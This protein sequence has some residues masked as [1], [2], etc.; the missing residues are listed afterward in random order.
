MSPCGDI[1][2]TKG[3]DYMRKSILNELWFGNLTPSEKP[4]EASP[5]CKALTDKRFKI[6]DKLCQM[7]TEQQLTLLSEYDDAVEDYSST[8]SAEAF[9]KGYGLGVK[10]TM[11][12]MEQ[13]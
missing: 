7:L 6:R 5:N 8:L 1:I 13:E 2:I 9:A 12:V 4:Y 3:D 10:I 11:E